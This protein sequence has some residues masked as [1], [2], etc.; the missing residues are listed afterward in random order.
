MF[1]ATGVLRISSTD[2]QR[3]IIPKTNVLVSLIFEMEVCF[4]LS[5]KLKICSFRAL[6]VQQS[7]AARPRNQVNLRPVKCP[8]CR[9]L[10][11]NEANGS[12]GV[13]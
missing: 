1:R 6:L 7:F 3:L 13:K 9:S 2:S 10:A 8:A 5:F 12:I 11:Q 4:S